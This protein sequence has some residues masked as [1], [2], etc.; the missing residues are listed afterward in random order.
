MN[1]GEMFKRA[2]KLAIDNSPAI[3]SAVA[4][5][6]TV[7]T[8]FLAGKATIKA[9]DIIREREAEDG[10]AED[11]HIRMR[12]RVELT[13]QLYIPAV[14]TGALTITCI[15]GANRIGTRRAAAMAAAFTLSEKAF[16]E[17]RT[18]VVEK[19][20]EKKEQQV[21]DELAQDR[22]RREPANS[23]QLVI[24]DGKSVLCYESFTG[25]Y[26][27]SDM[28]TLRKAQNDINHLVNNSYYASLTDFYNEIGL[29][30]TS[31]S[32]EVGW[33][34][35]KLLELKFST[36]LSEDGRPCIAIDYAVAPVRD[37]YRLA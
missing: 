14:T 27:I 11:P 25:R 10:F 6:G 3:L 35:D 31:M 18:K 15:I 23:S 33:N 16:E 21:R 37:Y 22:V 34:A 8:A 28:E 2:Q 7:A 30:A 20:G 36:V 1:L 13:W 32:D 26:F 19:I 5:T 12:H 4:V 24:I 9:V 17:Y 29:S